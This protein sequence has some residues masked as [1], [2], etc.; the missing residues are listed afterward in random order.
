LVSVIQDTKDIDMQKVCDAQDRLAL[1]IATTYKFKLL[2]LYNSLDF[3][4]ISSR[5]LKNRV[6]MI[7]SPLDTNEIVELA[8]KQYNSSKTMTEKIVA[9]SVLEDMECVD[10]SEYLRDFYQEYSSNS[11]VMSKYFALIASSSRKNP[12]PKLKFLLSNKLLD[13]Q[14]SITILKNLAFINLY[15]KNFEESYT[16]FNDLIDNKKIDDYKTLFYGAVASILAGHHSNA[17]ALLALSKR[18]NKNAFESRYG[19]GLLYHEV[20]NLRGAII[21][22]SKIPDGFES[23][24]FDFDVVP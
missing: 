16:I 4:S 22:Y 12:L 10:S 5:A 18:K 19:L 24:F 3:M 23:E 8:Q 6:L 20:K 7:L 9:L 14:D 17:V 11:L 21:Q 15:T 1:K 13:T 2:S